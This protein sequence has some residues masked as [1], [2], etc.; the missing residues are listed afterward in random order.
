[1]TNLANSHFSGISDCKMTKNSLDEGSTIKETRYSRV[2]VGISLQVNGFPIL[3]S[4]EI[5]SIVYRNSLESKLL[6]SRPDK[7]PLWLV[8]SRK[9]SFRD[10]I[11]SIWDRLRKRMLR[12][13][14][15]NCTLSP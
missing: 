6:V 14:K 10:E 12:S 2:L 9:L 11:P 8:E 7:W 4:L 13:D 3:A 5:Y 1:M 15:N